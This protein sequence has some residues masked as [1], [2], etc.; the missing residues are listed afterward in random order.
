MVPL[1][2]VPSGLTT[3]LVVT[4]L[5]RAAQKGKVKT[6][7][8]ALVFD[9]IVSMR[10]LLLLLIV[11]FGAGCFY[12]A[13]VLRDVW[14]SALCVALSFG[15]TI[16]YPSPIS[17]DDHKIQINRWYASPKCIAWVDVKRLE[18][19]GG[20]LTTIVV[21]PSGKKIAHTAIYGG[22]SAFQSAC[23]RHTGLKIRRTQF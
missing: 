18:Y 5:L 1:G 10:V 16:A 7:D 23:E 14:F 3:Y 8:G 11:G 13:F 9:C 20:P 17:I 21:G 6:K 19:H 12:I 22:T 2:Y 15:L 4:W